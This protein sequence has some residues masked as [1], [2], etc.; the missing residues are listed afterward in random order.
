M[1]T[2]ERRRREG[3]LGE[4][5][6]PLIAPAIAAEPGGSAVVRWSVCD[7][8]DRR[9]SWRRS[10]QTSEVMTRSSTL[11]A[12]SFTEGDTLEEL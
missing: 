4:L 9:F 3:E 12:R 11:T 8:P 5:D 2:K 10:H 6:A 7:S 1:G